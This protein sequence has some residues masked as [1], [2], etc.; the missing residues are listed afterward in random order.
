VEYTPQAYLQSDLQMF[1]MNYSTDLLGLEPIM[2]SID[3]GDCLER[4]SL[5][6][7]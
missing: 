3:G 4:S 7:A 6:K 1:A 5:I 2:V